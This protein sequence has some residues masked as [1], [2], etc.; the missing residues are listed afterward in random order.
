LS[1]RGRCGILD[2]VGALTYG[3]ADSESSAMSSGHG[4]QVPGRHPHEDGLRDTSRRNLIVALALTGIF[5]T[6]EVVA[7]LVWGSL[8]L[9]SDAGHMLTDAGA[10]GLALWAQ[11]LAKRERT[12]RKTFGFRRAEILAAAAN[13]IV[14]GVTAAV[15]IIEAVRRLA[16]PP[17]VDGGPMLLV[18]AAGLVVN[19]IAAWVLSRG[20]SKSV[21]V[22][23]AAAHVLADAA[24]SVAAIVAALLILGPGWTIADPIISILISGLIV[25]GA[26]RLLR[27]SV[28]ILMEG[29]PA[30][31]DVPALERLVCETVGV[32]GAH[33][34]H[35]WSIADDRPAV[36]VHVIL[37][38][39]HH[40]AV[41][42]RDV[43]RR[44][45]EAIHG[46]H[47]TVQPEAPLPEGRLV[48]PETLIRR[49]G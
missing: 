44:L 39:G 10:L 5:L 9:L 7:G 26:W 42:A 48:P 25:A 11:A 17:H 43:G 36:T 18:A 4:H 2:V 21:N 34:L 23:A 13:G 27:E 40:G 37:E 22:R 8:A 16:S 12:G 38:A 24:G 35:V 3:E 31:I 1:S 15:V 6:V 46:A 32:T 14:L 41:V 28:N 19:L 47:V 20:A 33:D 29:V 45:E 30:G 49:P